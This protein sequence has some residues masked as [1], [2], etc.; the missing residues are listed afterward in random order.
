MKKLKQQLLTQQKYSYTEQEQHTIPW[1]DT[2]I[3]KNDKICRLVFLNS[4]GI[5]PQHKFS[6]AHIIGQEAA[7]LQTDIL[8]LAETN[9]DWEQGNTTSGCTNILRNYW[10]QKKIGFSSSTN[11]NKQSGTTSRSY[12]PGGT[13]MVVGFPWASRSTIKNDTSGMGRW[14]EAELLGKRNK[15]LVIITAYNVC[16]GNIG[17]IGP[18]TAFVQQYHIIKQKDPTN[19]P[20]PRTQMLTDLGKRIHELKNNKSEVILMWDAN[21]TLQKP[22]SE[23]SK[24]VK[25]MGMLDLVTMRHGTDDEPP[26]YSR[27]SNRIDYTMSTPKIAEYTTAAG[28]LPLHEICISNHRPIFADIDIN[29]Y[30]GGETSSILQRV[31]RDVNGDNP[32]SVIKYQQELEKALDASKIEETIAALTETMSGTEKLELFHEQMEIVD[33]LFM[34]IRLLCEKKCK[35]KFQHP[36]SP[37]L[38]KEYFNNIFWNLW[39]SELK[40]NRSLF[41][42]REKYADEDNQQYI[43]SCNE[44]TI[45]SKLKESQKKL[46]E[47]RD[48]AQTIRDVFLEDRAKLLAMEGKGDLAAIVARI[49]KMES[50]KLRFA[51]LKRIMGKGNSGP[52]DHILVEDSNGILMRI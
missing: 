34:D 27:G 7:A 36:L 16:K 11:K 39:L 29:A 51:K 14:T 35:Q 2:P 5:S 46:K 18:R 13:M 8:G 48:N 37:V 45:K 28:I 22:N 10:K 49:R 20:N 47:V 15:K 42:K 24:W 9:L 6:K 12:R 44:T 38:Q 1:G 50:D 19:V 32:R 21:D 31:S 3:S 40:N 52:M 43:Y 23:L 17:T 41:D 26:T 30:L 25:Q 4:N 33:T